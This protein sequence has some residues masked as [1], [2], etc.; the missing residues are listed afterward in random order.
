MLVRTVSIDYRPGRVTSIEGHIDAVSSPSALTPHR[1]L[2]ELK[3]EHG[4]RW[5]CTEYAPVVVAPA[6]S[7]QVCKSPKKHCRNNVS[8]PGPL[9]TPR[10]H[11]RLPRTRR[12]VNTGVVLYSQLP[13]ES[14]G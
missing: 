7:R 13:R 10:S 12:N 1:Q 8:Q 11:E 6:Q 3:L 9:D 14:F 5:R 4:Y 2:W